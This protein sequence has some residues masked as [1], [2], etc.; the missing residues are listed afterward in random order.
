MP[1]A[2]P[3]ARAGTHRP[4]ATPAI[5]APTDIQTRSCRS[6]ASRRL[7]R[8]GLSFQFSRMRPARFA[9]LDQFQRA[10]ARTD[11]YGCAG[12]GKLEFIAP[13]QKITRAGGQI[14]PNLFVNG[15]GPAKL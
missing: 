11:R 5:P 14:G 1:N 9:K 10:R 6:C 12:R 8:L 13:A 4:A 3:R 15:N 2:C 7:G